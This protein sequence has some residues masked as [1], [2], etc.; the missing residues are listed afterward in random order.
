[1]AINDLLSRLDNVK[2]TG[3]GRWVAKCPAHADKS[4]SL[5]IREMDD[6][7]ILLH[8][9]A[10]CETEAVLQ[11]VGLTFADLMPESVGIQKMPESRP[12]TTADALRCISFEAVLVAMAASRIASGQPI[13]GCARDRLMLACSRIKGALEGAG[14]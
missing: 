1:M 2:K 14:L 12:F 4:P 5:S 13:D 7:R 9:F 3:H 11:A 6:G 10:G 8:D